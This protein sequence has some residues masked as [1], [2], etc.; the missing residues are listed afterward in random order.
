MTAEKLK[1][2]LRIKI[3]I[4]LVTGFLIVMMF[5]KGEAI[6]SEVNVGT[7]WIQDD[8]IAS[9]SFPILKPAEQ[10]KRE[11]ESAKNLVYNIYMRDDAAFEK[12]IDT[13]TAYNEFLKAT[14]EQDNKSEQGKFVPK[15]F[16][17]DNAYSFFKEQFNKAPDKQSV[18]RELLRVP[19]TYLEA[20][21][22]KG[23]L[24]RSLSNISG[25]SIALRIGNIDI[26]YPKKR[27]TD[28]ENALNEFSG[29]TSTISGSEYIVEYI[30]YFVAPNIQFSKELTEEEATVAKDRVSKYV[31]IV[32]ENERIVAKHDRITNETK[33]K[34]DSY[35]AARA[36]DSGVGGAILQFVGKF[37][38]ILSLLMLL[39]VYIYYFRQKIYRDNSRILLFAILFVFVSYL[40]YLAN[41][42]ALNDSIQF[43]I[44]VPSVAMLVTIIF[45]SRVGFYSTVL[46]SLIVG[47]LRGNDYSFAAM[48]IVAGSACVYT[49]RD[50]KNRSQIFRTFAYIVVGYGIT[51]LAFGLERFSPWT[52]IGSDF[53]FAAINGLISPVLTYGILI[54]VERF[55]KLTTDLTLQELTSYDHPLMR[56]LQSK[57]IGTF[58]HSIS[59]AGIVGSTAELI[60]AHKQLALVGAYYHDIGK[61]LTPGMF[62]E[63]QV[64]ERNMHEDL[65]PEKS[66]E[67]IRAHVEKGIQLAREH[68]LPPEVI[69]FIPTHHG[70]SIIAYFYDKAVKMYGEDKVNEA[71]YRYPGPKPFSKETA[72]V[73]LADGCESAVRSIDEPTPEKIEN[74]VV[75]LIDKKV[76]DHQLDETP[77]TLEDLKKIKTHFIAQLQGNTYKRIRYPKQEE[78]EKED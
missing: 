61:T 25:D 1:T 35:R 51:I 65:P 6:E 10:Y 48:N 33:L 49:V 15:V 42:F 53:A 75:N 20:Q 9:S 21:Y 62:V 68:K 32:A 26:I 8:L 50:I 55:F 37:L 64:G 34:I 23:I 13:I 46:I 54:F 18:F 52:K 69:D 30:S 43:L 38:H 45:D 47:A 31:G 66:V 4:L 72:L 39:A 57:A 63:N 56:E 28:K 3:L 76:S 24:E 60:G 70:T 12:L 17:S 14:I 36:E 5:P 59:M 67:Y 78:M 73:M 41:T 71:D 11:I 19:L 29:F 22:E 58:N 40:T 74:M 2:S 44:V 16:L 27:F 7:I 77:L